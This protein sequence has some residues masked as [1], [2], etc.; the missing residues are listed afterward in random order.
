MFK[1]NK[2]IANYLLRIHIEAKCV[3]LLIGIAYLKESKRRE[4]REREKRNVRN[5]FGKFNTYLYLYMFCVYVPRD[6]EKFNYLIYC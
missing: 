1:F 5:I 4:E 2:N 3:Y 6:H